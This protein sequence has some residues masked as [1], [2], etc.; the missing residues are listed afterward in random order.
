MIIVEIMAGLANRMFQYALY[1]NLEYKG[2]DVYVDDTY[3]PEKWAF[4]NV[5][6]MSIFP[7]VEYR[8]ASQHLINKMGGGNDIISKIRRKYSFLNNRDYIKVNT[9]LGFKQ[10][11]LFLNGDYYLS[12]IWMSDKYFSASSDAIRKCFMFKDFSDDNNIILQKE[13]QSCESVAIHIRKGPD[14]KNT[15]N[16]GV[17]NIDY[18][19]RAI[20]HIKSHVH[21]PVFYVFADNK[22]WAIENLKDIKYNLIDWNPISGPNNYLDMQLMSYAKHNIIANSTYSWWGAWL[23]SNENKICIL[24]LI[25]FNPKKVNK[26]SVELDIAPNRWMAL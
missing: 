4:E 24:P 1:K 25:W 20:N 22:K 26:T 13:M 6:L 2:Y 14:Y 11:I 23:N 7:N 16:D 18:Y 9:A 19:N 10:S 21:N 15:R 3:Q 8:R 17:A 12:G 5:E